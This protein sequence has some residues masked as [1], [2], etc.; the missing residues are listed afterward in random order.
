MDCTI[1]QLVI[2]DSAVVNEHT[3][4]VVE[5]S[6]GFALRFALESPRLAAD[7]SDLLC[8]ENINRN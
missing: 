8:V 7:P 1:T 2:R 6:L 5:V 3:N 4:G